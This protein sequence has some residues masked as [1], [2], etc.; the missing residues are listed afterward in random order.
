MEC[1]KKT[2]GRRYCTLL[3]SGHCSDALDCGDGESA[4]MKKPLPV[5]KG[6]GVMINTRLLVF[7]VW[8]C[9]NYAC[10]RQCCGVLPVDQLMVR[11]LP[12]HH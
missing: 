3:R 1:S 9:M 8:L 7:L 12:S 10:E 11:I 6:N 2:W 4:K 5:M